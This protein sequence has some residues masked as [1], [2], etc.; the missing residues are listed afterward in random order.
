MEMSI[1]LIE[2]VSTE[3]MIFILF[4]K[5]NRKNTAKDIRFMF[6][7]CTYLKVKLYL[8]NKY[9]FLRR[10]LFFQS[11]YLIKCIANEFN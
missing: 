2:N 3:L 11:L 8:L 9:L 4:C 6:F 5:V 1:M 7:Y 10:Y